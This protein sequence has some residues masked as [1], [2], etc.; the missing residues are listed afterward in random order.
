MADEHTRIPMSEPLPSHVFHSRD[1]FH[2][3]NNIYIES[4]P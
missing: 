4:T 2:M 3:E 1:V